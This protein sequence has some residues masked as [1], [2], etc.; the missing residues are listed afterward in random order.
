MLSQKE[1]TEHSVT[2]VE[3]S[4]QLVDV[5]NERKVGWRMYHLHD[6]FLVTC[7]WLKM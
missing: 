1:V 4:A 2:K 3:L 7:L 5:A 6:D